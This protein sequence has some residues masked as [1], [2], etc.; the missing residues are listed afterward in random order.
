MRIQIVVLLTTLALF[1][2][3]EEQVVKNEP[4]PVRGLRV[5]QVADAEKTTIRRYPS[6]V[7]PASITTLSFEIAGRLKDVNLNVGQTVSAGELLAEIDS[8]SLDL[9]VGSAQAAVDQANSTAK[10]AAED[11]K[12][13]ADL[14]KKGVTTK[15]ASD[16]ARTAAETRAAQVVQAQR[17]L[18][19]ANENLTKATL[20]APYDGILN[21]IEVQSFANVSVG[22]PV[23]TLY[24][25]DAFESRFSVSFEI[26]NKLAVGK[27][28]TIRL[29]DNPDIVLDGIISELGA[30]ADTVSSFPTVARL[31]EINPIVKAGMAV[32]IA[33]EFAVPSGQGYALPISVLPL[34]GTIENAGS[35]DEAGK[36]FVYVFDEATSTVKKRAIIIAGVRE[37]SLIVIDGLK[38][39]D[40]VAS[41]GVSFLREGQKVKL[42]S[43]NN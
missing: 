12:R 35:P 9:Q 22:S 13:K 7:Q 27:R 32:E 23:V 30:R 42:L 36:T 40:K 41:A 19:V 1:G 16:K 37:N 11:A 21:S 4:A 33:I 24:A 3:S 17:A 31:T 5:V 43:N 2:C 29:A 10:N 18:D 34:E 38:L 28:V 39:G 8:R 25:T 26:V 15:A 14:L 6:V 20:K